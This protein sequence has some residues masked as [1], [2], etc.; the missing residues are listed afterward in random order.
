MRVTMAD[1]AR[2]AG[3]N[4]ATVSRVLRG[5]SR[6]SAATREK[7][8]RTVKDL[9]YRP[10]AVARGL[11]GSST[12][13]VGV[14][15]NDLSA[16]WTGEFLS[17]LERVLGRVGKECIAKSTMGLQERRRNALLGLLA[18]HVDALVWCDGLP[19]H[20][21]NVA[22]VSIGNSSPGGV[23]I[24]VDDEAAAVKLRRLAAGRKVCHI[25]GENPLFPSVDPGSGEPAA[26][27]TL[28]VF[29]GAFGESPGVSDDAV[30]CG[31][32][33]MCVPAGWYRLLFPAFEM[34]VLAGRV[35]L[36]M[37]RGKGVRPE[38]VTVAPSLLSP[39]GEPL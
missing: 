33:S 35:L 15:F 22:C 29:D 21:E 2:E 6:I 13:T 34:G 28:L 9:G 24:A 26:R 30:V 27:G 32:Q 25:K 17:G 23:S 14:L 36:N 8:W 11:S 18:R 31:C 3:V 19:L 38:T 16:P 4:K 12:E 7:V 37:L 5:D 20:T 1:V 39:D 10:D